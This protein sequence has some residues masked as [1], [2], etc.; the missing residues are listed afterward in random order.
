[1]RRSESRGTTYS[2][3]VEWLKR[4]VKVS[5]TLLALVLGEASLANEELTS[6]RSGADLLAQCAA[7]EAYES[8]RSFNLDAFG[9]CL[10]YVSGAFDGLGVAGVCT[11]NKV[12]NGQMVRVV[13]K[14]LREHPEELHR[15]KLL[16]V[17]AAY[18]KA[19]PCAAT[20]AK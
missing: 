7:F 12:S 15:D 5:V 3:L 4:W 1:M 8:G 16:L 10:G 19:W 18:L 14:Y 11:P 2:S 6:G 9:F 20:K 17:S 13:L